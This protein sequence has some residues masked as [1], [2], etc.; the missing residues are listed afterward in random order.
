[1]P[2]IAAR[3]APINDYAA[4]SHRRWVNS[5][6]N[7]SVVSLARELSASLEIGRL[8]RC[9]TGGSLERQ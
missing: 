5:K 8:V 7:F 9:E 3:D 4:P 1:M 2:F 6:S